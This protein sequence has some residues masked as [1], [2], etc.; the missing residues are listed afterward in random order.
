MFCELV[1]SN[2]T[3]SDSMNDVAKVFSTII[4]SEVSHDHVEADIN[5]LD[6]FAME[7]WKD[8][9]S[10]NTISCHNN[11]YRK[12]MYHHY[13]ALN[14]YNCFA[15]DESVKTKKHWGRHEEG[16]IRVSQFFETTRIQDQPLKKHKHLQ[17]KWTKLRKGEN[18]R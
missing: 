1:I 16:R 5:N 6:T 2:V 15:S 12:H 13:S 9:I 17:E 10:C 14:D 8:F 4:W 11:S 18:P 3:F 7:H